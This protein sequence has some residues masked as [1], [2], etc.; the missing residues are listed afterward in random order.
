[1][2][3]AI[4][5]CGTNTFHLMIVEL[6]GKNDSRIVFKTKFAVKLG[7]GGITKNIISKEPFERGILALQQFSKRIVLHKAEMVIAVATAAVRGAK[8]SDQFIQQ[9]KVRA[10]INIQLING[11]REAELIYY[12]VREALDLGDQPSLIVDIGGGS[13]EFIICNK[14]K[15]FWQKSFSLGAALLLEKLKPVDP[16]HTIEI[17]K[18]NSF[19]ERELKPLFKAC[20]LHRPSTLVGSSGSFETFAEMIAFQKGNTEHTMTKTAYR[21][22][23][24]D[25]GKIHRKL[26]LSTT[27]ERMKMK[28]LVKMRV[29]MIVLASLLLTFVLS[30][31]GIKK[32]KLSTYA[33][34]EGILAE[35]SEKLRTNNMHNPRLASSPT[36][37]LLVGEDANLG[38][39]K[40]YN[41]E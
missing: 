25:Y 29:D 4:I 14:H 23:M 34:K 37:M 2:K 7:Q 30:K 3:I 17:E 11:N 21:F 36:L 35:V 8:N 22:S 39:Y 20:G 28:G 12:G 18:L 40:K 10:G 1:M 38:Q 33:L 31:T 13:T 15:V 19:L 6:H 24:F 32:M 5:D 16:I 9:A 26:L 27:A 41:H